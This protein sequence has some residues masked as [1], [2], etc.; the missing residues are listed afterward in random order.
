M[1]VSIEHLFSVS[2]RNDFVL[3]SV[4]LKRSAAVAAAVDS[5]GAGSTTTAAAAAAE[6]AAEE[7]EEEGA[8]PASSAGAGGTSSSCSSI[9]DGSVASRGAPSSILARAH[10]N[11]IFCK[12]SVIQS[13]EKG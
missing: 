8:V 13:K 7:E 1:F 9:G 4:S 5:T 2:A 10:T 6:A 12:N 3:R 11:N